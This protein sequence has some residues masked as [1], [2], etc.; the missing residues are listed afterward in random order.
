MGWPTPGCKAAIDK[1][2]GGVVCAQAH[3]DDTAAGYLHDYCACKIPPTLGQNPCPYNADSPVAQWVDGVLC[4]C[5]CMC[6]AYGTPIEIPGNRQK[7]I[8]EF[9]VGDLVMAANVGPN[10]ELTWLPKTVEF[11]NGTGDITAPSVMVMVLFQADGGEDYLIVTKNHLFLMPSGRLKRADTLVPGQ[12]SLVRA[13]GT[14]TP[15]VGLSVGEI[16]KGVH[17][18]ATSLT[19]TTTMNG[20]LLNSKGIVSADYALQISNIEQENAGIMVE[21]HE[22]LPVFG[23]E[24]YLAAYAGAYAG[25][26]GNSFRVGTPNVNFADYSPEGFRH[27]ALDGDEELKEVPADARS[28]IT[29]DQAKDIQRDAPQLPP[30]S[31]AG[32]DVVYYLFQLYKGFYPEIEF[33]LD[34]DSNLPNA[35]AFKDDEG[36]ARIRVNGGL[37]R[38]NA[39]KFNS[40]AMILA[41]RIGGMFGGPPLNDQGYS[42]EGQADYSGVGVVLRKIWYGGLYGDIV[43]PGLKELDEFFGYI[44]PDNSTGV[45][46]DTCTY[47]S[48]D[49]RKQAMNA[50]LMSI[51]LPEC[52]GGPK[53]PFLEVTAASAA[54]DGTN[55]IVTVSFN[56][57]VDPTT[58]GDLSNY[59]LT[60]KGPVTAAALDPTDSTKLNL[61]VEIEL[62]EEY[63]I[64]VFNVLSAND[65]P[66]VPGKNRATFTLA[67]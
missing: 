61:T 65:E 19:T 14:T 43:G 40:L 53:T 1:I 6:F 2:P 11:S 26:T 20:H 41:N 35:Y 12:D 21:G 60:P 37:L 31:T 13:D 50:A 66:I 59:V 24:A 48:I 7:V 34:L 39:I 67:S 5:C 29:K 32:I 42:C 51:P 54:V 44:S 63:T 58:V 57:D 22:S 23:T 10:N 62:D 52:A 8:E 3:C 46:G 25:V 33:E 55:Q 16:N 64:R 18:I 38:I 17:H 56:T 9:Q 49:C 27:L 36:I 45:P 30:G 4:F 15:V 47:I 28:Y